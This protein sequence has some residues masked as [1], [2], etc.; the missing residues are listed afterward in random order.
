M[1]SPFPGMDPFIESQKWE[2]FHLS[3]I[4]VMRD[5]L[6]GVVGDQYVV[7]IHERVYLESA[8]E[9]DLW[10]VSDVSVDRIADLGKAESS[11]KVESAVA[12]APVECLLP[13][14]GPSSEPFLEI[15]TT[16]GDRLVT[17]IEL[18]SP[19]NK[20]PKSAGSRKY[21]RKRRRLLETRVNLVEL[22]LWCGGR[23]LPM[24]SPLPAGHYMAMVSRGRS[25]PKCNVYAWRLPDRMPSIP[26]PLSGGDAEPT[27]DFQTVPDLVYDRAQYRRAIKYNKPCRPTLTGEMLEWVDS[28]VSKLPSNSGT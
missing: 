28:I 24:A 2:D 9:E 21:L 3:A 12:V 19:S 7:N 22:D 23:R 6:V 25:R 16:D 10:I 11:V 14:V 27:L 18:L 13:K 5:M 26:I 17:V 4:T 8:V 1:P 20:R 15:R